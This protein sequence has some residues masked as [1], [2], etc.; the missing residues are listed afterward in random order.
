MG[1][2]SRLLGLEEAPRAVAR[3]P[4]VRVSPTSAP[5]TGQSPRRAVRNSQPLYAERNWRLR[6]GAL[7]GWYRTA[8]GAYEGRI[9]QPF[10]ASTSYFIFSPPQALLDGEHGRCFFQRGPRKFEVHFS[11]K[12]RDVNAGILTLEHTL[13]E[14]LT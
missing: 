12:P 3:S 11:T 9:E 5:A 14:A 1:L 8:R 2:F 10:G 6:D 4:V 13:L 7:V